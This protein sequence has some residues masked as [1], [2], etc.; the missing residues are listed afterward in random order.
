MKD[1][2]DFSK[3]RPNP[4][5]ERM[6]NGYRIVIDRGLKGIEKDKLTPEEMKEL[7]EYLAETNKKPSSVV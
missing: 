6:K 7:Q 5:A 1:N 3:A 2:Y 4:Y